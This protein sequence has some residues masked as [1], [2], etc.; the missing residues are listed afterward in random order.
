MA[1]TFSAQTDSNPFQVVSDLLNSPLLR[2]G[3]YLVVVFFV[4][5]WLSVVYWTFIVADRRGTSRFFW[6]SVALIFPFIGTL[7]YVIVRPP[8]Y[9]LDSRERELD[10]AVLEREF[11][12]RADLC[13]NCRSVVE[14]EYLLCRE[15]GWDLKSPARTAGGSCAWTGNLPVLR[16]RAEQKEHQLVGG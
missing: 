6:A 10:L 8:E 3:F 12:R 13:P 1:L 16:D 2:I 5:L 9:L 15:C 4:L 14:K 7:I 11:R